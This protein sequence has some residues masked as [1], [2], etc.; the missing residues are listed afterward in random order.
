M[1]SVGVWAAKG[2]A[3]QNRC[4]ISRLSSANLPCQTEQ[5]E[6]ADNSSRKTPL[7]GNSP[8]RPFLKICL[9][10]ESRLLS[11]KLPI[12]VRQ[13]IG[14]DRQHRSI[15]P[16][17]VCIHL[18]QRVRIRVMPVEVVL[19]RRPRA[20]R[21]NTIRG[22]RLDVRSATARRNAIRANRSKQRSDVLQI[23]KR[24]LLFRRKR[25][26]VEARA[27]RGRGSSGT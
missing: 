21:R 20:Q 18:V 22:N 5:P 6:L 2:L 3:H 11:R 9:L 26:Q 19:A 27:R 15:L 8:E 13:H 25:V 16:E 7:R 10:A 23:R 1:R 24:M 14:N 12:H 17:R 4:W